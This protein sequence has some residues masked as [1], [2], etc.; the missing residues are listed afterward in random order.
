ML[1]LLLPCDQLMRIAWLG[2]EQL[3]SNK[4]KSKIR[5]FF[6]LPHLV[7][8]ESACP[9]FLS[10]YSDGNL[11]IYTEQSSRFAPVGQRVIVVS[12]FMMRY[13]KILCALFRFPC[14]FQGGFGLAYRLSKNKSV[15]SDGILTECLF[16]KKY[17]KPSAF[18]S[19]SNIV[20]RLSVNT[21]EQLIL[22]NN[23]YEFGTFSLE[24][25]EN[26]L[27]ALNRAY[28]KAN[29]FPH[30]KEGRDIPRRI[31]GAKLLE[32]DINIEAYCMSNGLPANIIGFLGSTSM[33]SLGKL[34]NS[35]ITIEAINI[36][37]VGCDGPAGSVTD[38]LLLAKKSIRV[39]LSDLEE[40]VEYILKLAPYVT[41]KKK[42]L[43]LADPAPFILP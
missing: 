12:T 13:I 6:A 11:F 35:K 10:T 18:I 31:F 8:V 4:T 29:Y 41:I 25:Y 1:S 37:S 26:F 19:V 22:G 30:P 36:S 3:A 20:P 39:T 23:W 7:F 24:K 21:G 17:I 15:I 40:T 14:T 34:A 28:P 9:A 27:R 32:S 2:G 38:P 16:Q 5:S 43:M 42:E 33:A